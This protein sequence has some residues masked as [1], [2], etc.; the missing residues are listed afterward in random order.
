MVDFEIIKS[1]TKKIVF[2]SIS[3]FKYRNFRISRLKKNLEIQKILNFDLEM[4]NF[5]I[6]KSQN[7][8]PSAVSISNFKLRDFLISKLKKYL[9]IV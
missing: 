6:I 7:K 5:E 2:L 4:G 1:Q 9:E 3:N 8:K